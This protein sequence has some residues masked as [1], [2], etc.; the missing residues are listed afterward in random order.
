MLKN[1]PKAM[2]DTHEINTNWAP[3]NILIATKKQYNNQTDSS[4]TKY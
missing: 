1:Y 2:K 4:A 3:D